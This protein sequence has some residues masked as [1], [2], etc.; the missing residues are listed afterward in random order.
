ML[1]QSMLTFAAYGPPVPGVAGQIANKELF[2]ERAS[3]SLFRLVLSHSST[4]WLRISA[5][6]AL[7]VVVIVDGCPNTSGTF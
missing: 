5:N 1:Q 7:V 2:Y 6:P 4:S 3:S